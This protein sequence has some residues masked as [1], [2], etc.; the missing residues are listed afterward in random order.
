[1]PTSPNHALAFGTVS[2]LGGAVVLWHLVNPLTAALGVA[3][4]V[5]YAGLYTPLK[6]I[7]IANTWVGSVVG[8]IPPLM[9]WTACTGTLDSGALVLA[10]I[11]YTWQFAHFNALSWG[12]REDYFRAGYR[13][14]SVS[15]PALCK[16]VALR[17][18]VATIPVCTL[19]PMC[20]LTTWMF[21]ADSLP[22]NIW[23]V[24]LAWKFYRDSDSKSAQRLFRY[25]LLHLPLL[26]ALLVINK[27]HWYGRD[28]GKTSPAGDASGREVERNLEGT[29]NIGQGQE[30]IGQTRDVLR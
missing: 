8:A 2:G 3:N 30:D 29:G 5:L 24:L 17:Y 15:H 13:M 28:A 26:M 9:G 16:R 25:S 20:D 6:R 7:T 21:A 11:L 18:S 10:G 27:K 4:V 22:V 12:L 19:A 23:L 1:M 14:M